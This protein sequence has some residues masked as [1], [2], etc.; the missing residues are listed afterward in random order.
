M[1]S[2]PKFP[3]TLIYGST[4]TDERLI[5]WVGKEGQLVTAMHDTSC[6]RRRILF[7]SHSFAVLFRINLALYGNYVNLCRVCLSMHIYSFPSHGPEYQDTCS[8]T[9]G[10]WSSQLEYWVLWVRA[11]L[12]SCLIL[13]GLLLVIWFFLQCKSTDTPPSGCRGESFGNL[14]FKGLL[15]YF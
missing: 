11:T 4:L 2:N 8:C 14:S 7:Q 5:I 10:N 9:H 6:W 3:S 12:I 15:S 1:N 13:I